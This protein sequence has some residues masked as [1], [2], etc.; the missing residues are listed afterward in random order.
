MQ[1]KNQIEI[2]RKQR[3]LIKSYG[4]FVGEALKE[5]FEVNQTN[6]NLKNFIKWQ[7]TITNQTQLL[8]GFSINR[9]ILRVCKQYYEDGCKVTQIKDLIQF[10]LGGVFGTGLPF[11][12]STSYPLGFILT[13]PSAITFILLI[14]WKRK[15][16]MF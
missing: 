12:F 7:D 13:I 2:Q 14:F 8:L 5:L 10:I 4:E 6:P 3:L 11:I 9:P 1:K 16:E 15:R